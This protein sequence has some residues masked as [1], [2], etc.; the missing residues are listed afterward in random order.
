[1]RID[2]VRAFILGAE[3]TLVGCIA[4]PDSICITD[5][6]VG[7]NGG[8]VIETNYNVLDV[9]ECRSYC[10]DINATMFTFHDRNNDRCVCK[11]KNP[12]DSMRKI[13]S[14]GSTSGNTF[15]FRELMRGYTLMTS[16]KIFGPSSKIVTE[17]H[18]LS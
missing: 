10:R 7:Y 16:T 15:C 3:M 8:D 5:V 13:L 11:N 14:P 9:E 4:E 17:M 6:S 12:T 2:S 1:M 18:Y